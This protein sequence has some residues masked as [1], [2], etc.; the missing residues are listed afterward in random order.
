MEYLVTDV[1]SVAAKLDQEIGARVRW[2]RKARNLTQSDLGAAI[3]VTF[4][5]IQKYERGANRISTSALILLARALEVSPDD[6]LALEA[7]AGDRMEWTLLDADGAEDVLRA[8][9]EIA[10][11]RLRRVLCDLARSL[12]E[13]GPRAA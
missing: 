13:A 5:Q 4:Q 11:P 9:K 3:G 6:L 2:V 8:Y 10:S 1:D 12:S 7:Q